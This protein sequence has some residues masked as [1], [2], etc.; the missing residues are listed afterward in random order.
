MIGPM[1]R[2]SAVGAGARLGRQ[3]FQLFTGKPA[4]FSFFSRRAKAQTDREAPPRPAAAGSARRAPVASPSVDQQRAAARRTA[5]QIDRIES[6]MIVPPREDAS[7]MQPPSAAVALATRVP[8]TPAPRTA[9]APA[10]SAGA[11]VAAIARAR[12]AQPAAPAVARASASDSAAVPTMKPGVKPGA[13]AGDVPPALPRRAPPAAS[14]APVAAVAGLEP[15]RRPAPPLEALVFT[16]PGDPPAAPLVQGAQSPQGAESPGGIELAEPALPPEL[17]EAAILFANG[18]SA[19][20]AAT[21]EA[22]VERDDAS[23]RAWLMLLD[24]LHASGRRA[25]F[26][27]LCIAYAARFETSPP[28]WRDAGEP[29]E[30]PRRVLSTVLVA[31]GERIDDDTGRAIE[32]ARKAAQQKRAMI[33]D[34]SS[35]ESVDPEAALPLVRLL[36]ALI[37]GRRE[38]TVRGARRLADAARAAIEPGRRDPVTGGWQ[39]ALM[40]LRLL[41]EQAAFEDLSIDYCVTFEVSPPS[42]EPVPP[43]LSLAMGS[44]P[45]A[46]TA[47]RRADVAAPSSAA[48][49]TPVV[50]VPTVPAGSQGALRLRGE[51]AGLIAAELGELRA[52]AA[53]RREVLIDAR[54]LLRLDFVAAG[55]LL[56]EIVA[57]QGLGRTVVIDEPSHVVEALLV[58][59]GVR[60]I[61]RIRRRH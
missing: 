47:E 51:L 53:D 27:T 42:W 30:A 29:A 24:V 4:V 14:A 46:A 12:A 49:V 7:V 28:T 41:G 31:F 2:P 15:E 16:L 58:V 60:D 54:D 57:L 21:L 22:V 25:D 9:A 48:Q 8:V 38:V 13:A 1:P 35:L 5:E 11:A 3:L 59:M 19:A 56:N 10:V 37:Q 55:E 33:L 20:A 36:D 61:A 34:F 17:E 40:A 52:F 39:L 32:Q 26:E 50:Q 23:R 43:P 6:E 18:Q 44:E 45:M